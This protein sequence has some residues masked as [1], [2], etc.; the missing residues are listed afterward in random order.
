MSENQKGY[1]AIIPANVRYDKGLK[2]NEKL[3]YGEIVSLCNDLGSCTYSN[4]YFSKLFDTNKETVSRWLSNLQKNQYIEIIKEVGIVD[5]LKQK[6][7]Q[8]LGFGTEICLW[9]KIKTSVL[10][11]HHYPVPKS[12]GGT[13]TVGICPNCHHEYHYNISSIK[14]TLNNHSL[15]ELL[16]FRGEANG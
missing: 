9:C 8:G 6:N 14:L 11:Q 4:D 13:E 5:K 15:C 10:H 16:K 1:Y 3:L 7:L 2:A 12:E